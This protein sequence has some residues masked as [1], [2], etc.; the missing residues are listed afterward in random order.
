MATIRRRLTLWY[1]VALAVTVLAFGTALY[2]ARRQAS[3]SELDQ[4]LSLEADLAQRWLAQ[5]YRVL[6]RIVTTANLNPA[7]DPGIS[8]YLEAARDYLV[9]ADTTGNVLALSDDPATVRRKVLGM[10]TDPNRVRADVPG[11]VEG[12]P[13]FL[14]HDLFNA[15]REEVE[16]LETRYREGRV[17]DVEVKRKLANALNEFLAPHRERRAAFEA[18]PGLVEDILGQG[19][20]RLREIGAET[21]ERVRTAMGLTYYR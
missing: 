3:L 1:T 2:Y 20:A 8:A 13:V 5:S 12:N 10:Y 19:N 7:L 9:V 16:D 18:T 4:R 15:N 6:G 17:G 14:Y 11:T 21:L